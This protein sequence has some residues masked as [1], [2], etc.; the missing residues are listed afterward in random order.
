[1]RNRGPS[2]EELRAGILSGSTVSLAKAITLAE[3]QIE[4]DRASAS[5]LIESLLPH[6][7]KSVRLAIS[8]VPGVGKSTFI[9]SLGTYL[10]N[11]QHKVA[12]LAVDPSSTMTHGSILGDKTRMEKLSKNPNAFVRPT[13]A[14][15][16]LGGVAGRTR[17]AI[18]LC[19]A[20]GFDLIIIE[21]VG[22]GQSEIA[23]RG[24]VDYVLLL[25]LAGAGDELQGIKKGILEIADGIAINKADGDNVP[26]AMRAKA[27]LQHALHLVTSSGVDGPKVMLC[28]ALENSGIAEIWKE[29]ELFRERAM[30]DGSWQSRRSQQQLTW[31]D[32]S[33]REIV[34]RSVQHSKEA[35]ADLSDLEKD[36]SRA[37]TYPPTAA[38]ELWKE[39]VKHLR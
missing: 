2:V 15:G 27:E 12:V 14:S 39:L 9:E 20:A 25:M 38:A 11:I 5:K 13:A 37:N 34:L 18:L 7:G 21:T 35:V 19:E 10:T 8:G 33:L 28:S 1:M 30:T 17:E 16:H 6:T 22:V 3:S 29:V 24:M 36:V 23:V 4:S 26:H 32:E 31:M